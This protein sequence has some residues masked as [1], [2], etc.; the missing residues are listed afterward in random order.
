MPA[1]GQLKIL[2]ADD[3]PVSRRLMER[4]LQHS[5]YDVITVDNGRQAAAELSREGGPRLA[6]ID[7]MMPEL[8]GPG[9]CREVR[10]RHDS[11]VY[12]MLLTGKQSGGDVV[13]GL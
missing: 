5:G 2:V 9:V 12:I 4:T 7:W 1:D 3:D 11:Y 13:E 10:S 6:L 8:D